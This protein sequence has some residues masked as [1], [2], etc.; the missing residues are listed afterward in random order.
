MSSFIV[1]GGDGYKM[2]PENLIEHRNTGFLDN[3][4]LGENELYRIDPELTKQLK[5]KTHLLNPSLVHQKEHPNPPAH[6][7]S[8]RHSRRHIGRRRLRRQR[9]IHQ[10]H[11]VRNHDC[12]FFSNIGEGNKVKLKGREQACLI[13]NCERRYLIISERV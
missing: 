13:N 6:C 1:K 9:R 10:H 7:R 5:L 11:F 8:H 4:L 3:D 12:H 2:I